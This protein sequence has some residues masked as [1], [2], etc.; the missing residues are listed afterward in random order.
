MAEEEIPTSASGLKP[1]QVQRHTKEQ[2]IAGISSGY[3]A[4]EVETW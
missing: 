3:S 4:S 2:W 1:G